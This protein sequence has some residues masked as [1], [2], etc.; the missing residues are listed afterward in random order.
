MRGVDIVEIQSSVG[1]EAHIPGE[2]ACQ[3]ACEI[4]DLQN[5]LLDSRVRGRG[6]S[7]RI[8]VRAGQNERVGRMQERDIDG[9][10]SGDAAVD[11]GAR[12][13]VREDELAIVDDGIG[14]IDPADGAAETDLQCAVRTDGRRAAIGI[15]VGVDDRSVVDR[16]GAGSGN[17]AAIFEE[18]RREIVEVQRAAVGD[19]ASR[20]NRSLNGIGA[21]LQRAAVDRGAA[22]PGVARAGQNERA[23]RDGVIDGEGA[24]AGDVAAERDLCS[25]TYR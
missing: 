20:R 19:V 2:R 14:L 21:D 11:F 13:D 9:A 17:H 6:R 5:A 15:G 1:A 22:G 12:T 4:A 8:A 23:V 16:N 18:I 24:G 25:R 10:C 3:G 7:A